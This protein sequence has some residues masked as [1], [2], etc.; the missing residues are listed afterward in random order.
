[1]DGFR[2][3]IRTIPLMFEGQQAG[4][5]LLDAVFNSLPGNNSNIASS[6]PL[7]APAA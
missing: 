7:L 2:P 4:M 6:P 1:M 3:G 5:I